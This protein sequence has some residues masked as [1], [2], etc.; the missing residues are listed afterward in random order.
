MS[1]SSF[2]STL[3][4]ASSSGQDNNRSNVNLSSS[5]DDDDDEEYNDEDM[6]F[7]QAILKAAAKSKTTRTRARSSSIPNRPTPRRSSMTEV[8]DALKSINATPPVAH[9]RET[10]APES[11]PS[12]PTHNTNSRVTPPSK[13]N[14]ST[15]KQEETNDA[16]N[17]TIPHTI[18]PT[19]SATVSATATA[20]TTASSSSSSSNLH[21]DSSSSSSLAT[22]NAASAASVAASMHD[23]QITFE[24]T[25]MVRV[26]HLSEDDFTIPIVAQN[27]RYG[28]SNLVEMIKF[29]KQSTDASF[30]HAKTHVQNGAVVPISTLLTS[31]D[32]C[33]S[34]REHSEATARLHF[35]Y[36]KRVKRFVC[37]MAEELLIELQT[38][39]KNLELKF[40]NEQNELKQRRKA[41][42]AKKTMLKTAHKELKAA[43]LAVLNH[44]K[45][46]SKQMSKADTIGR[47]LEETLRGFLFKKGGGSTFGGKFGRRNWKERLFVLCKAK[48][49]V[50]LL[51]YFATP[52]DLK[53][54]GTVCID[55]DTKC[56]SVELEGKKFA[57]VISHDAT[58]PKAR[59]GKMH[60]EM[61]IQAP[62][63]ND[64]QVWV[65]C[66]KETAELL[67]AQRQLGVG[68][69]ASGGIQPLSGLEGVT[70]L[71]NED[72]QDEDGKGEETTTGETKSSATTTTNNG[73]PASL[74]KHRRMESSMK[75]HKLV[76]LESRVRDSNEQVALTT[77]AVNA[78]S[79][80]MERDLEHYC[81]QIR[82]ILS[83]YQS[84]EHTRINITK[85]LIM[86]AIDAEEELNTRKSE[87]M[88]E[89]RKD[90]SNID[91]RKDVDYFIKQNQYNFTP[92]SY[93]PWSKISGNIGTVISSELLPEPEMD[94]VNP[95]YH[96][97]F[98]SE[99]TR[100][101]L[102]RGSQS[103]RPDSLQVN[104]HASERVQSEDQ[105]ALSWQQF[106][107]QY[108][109][110]SDA[111]SVTSTSS[112]NSH[113]R[114]HSKPERSAPHP[115]ENDE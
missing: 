23:S 32:A 114:S 75:D 33:V 48:E 25:L 98:L 11:I 100:T 29:W 72:I 18:Q 46:L 15:S 103:T 34:L 59:K 101:R 49:G 51:H 104:R 109:D 82:G 3:S 106:Q 99:N 9:K 78:A 108:S 7:R 4:R 97:G 69:T 41:L 53:P 47:G 56:K 74:R 94:N 91:P 81:C 55:A 8:E 45:G 22:A 73:P 12:L 89:L 17:S 52:T 113:R 68:E 102:C 83:S 80:S 111:A 57:F 19:I 90:V 24:D 42:K 92:H 10:T 86:D 40:K 96:S 21:Q 62:N 107:A 6:H 13:L 84:L 105:L 36:A 20:T 61:S 54:K 39:R 14:L 31:R 112:S 88:A 27:A 1:L 93:G 67:N 85:T 30:H 95:A 44:A 37:Q 5:S 71:D 60:Y 28:E 50:S 115:P 70:E 26:P 77:A 2:S 43:N 87:L 65:D 66:I 79:H 58:V 64:Q 63:E 16:S 110:P 35:Q 38:Q 76:G